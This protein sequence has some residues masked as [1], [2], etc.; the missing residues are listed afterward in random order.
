MD[1]VRESAVARGL[2]T[3]LVE[4]FEPLTINEVTAKVKD[5]IL[6]IPSLLRADLSGS[7]SAPLKGRDPSSASAA[8]PEVASVDT[9]FASNLD[10]I[11]ESLDLIEQKANV[12]ITA[13]DSLNTIQRELTQL[14]T[15]LKNLSGEILKTV[16]NDKQASQEVKDGVTNSKLAT[17]EVIENQIT[18]IEDKLAFEIKV[19]K[20]FRESK[21]I[22]FTSR[23]SVATT[24][25]SLE[26]DESKSKEPK[27]EI[28][29][30]GTRYKI[31]KLFIKDMHRG[32]SLN[33]VRIPAPGEDQIKNVISTLRA[34]L[35]P[36]EKIEAALYLA[37]QE[38]VVNDVKHKV[39]G[40][41]AD[42][43]PGKQI[44]TQ[45]NNDT[46]SYNIECAKFGF[47]EVK[48][49]YEIDVYDL[50]TMTLLTRGKVIATVTDLLNRN[51]NKADMS[52][53]VKEIP[54]P[55][56]QS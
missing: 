21:A 28:E 24:R 49:S 1:P 50:D 11:L 22:K 30:E 51:P 42:L 34:A 44:H 23:G 20:A 45:I 55:A 7:H 15:A 18:K 40:L 39:N 26:K 8:S 19:K 46:L 47:V 56:G 33:G 31:P 12:M 17:I 48:S 4:R 52:L 53:E 38:V 25:L 32:V 16:K 27:L 5:L 10:H 14:K 35:V 54:L 43:F 3:K 9:R 13:H 36:D 29:V 6:N 2:P 41:F 37:N